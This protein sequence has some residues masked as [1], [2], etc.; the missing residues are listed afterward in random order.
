MY[1]QLETLLARYQPSHPEDGAALVRMR[2]VLGHETK[3]FDRHCMPAHF[4]ASAWV[5]S[6]CGQNVALVHHKKL[7]KW[8]QPGG[9]ADGN[10]NMLAVALKELSEECGVTTVS[11]LPGIFDLDVHIIPAFGDTPSHEHLDVRFAMRLNGPCALSCS[12]ESHQV[13]WVRL[14]TLEKF[15]C[16]ASILRMRAKSSATK[17]LTT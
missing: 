16:E 1:T 14:A 11:I 7:E 9:H 13:D 10:P 6:H 17:P 12:T 3:C 8:L 5:L 15:S 4:T 2:E